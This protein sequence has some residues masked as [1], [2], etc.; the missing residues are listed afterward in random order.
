MKCLYDAYNFH[1][2]CPPCMLES[3]VIKLQLHQAREGCIQAMEIDASALYGELDLWYQIT[4]HL[5]TQKWRSAAEGFQRLY[6]M[7]C[8]GV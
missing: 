7:R 1:P 8:G 3:N 6:S 2:F 5:G 4:G